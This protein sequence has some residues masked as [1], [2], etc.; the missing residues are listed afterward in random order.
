MRLERIRALAL[1]TVLLLSAASA[2]VWAQASPPDEEKLRSAAM[3]Y[4]DCVARLLQVSNVSG[5]EMQRI[6]ELLS[7]NATSLSGEDLEKYVDRLREAVAELRANVRGEALTP[8][9]VVVKKMS[10]KV[11]ERLNKTG[12]VGAAS[13][14][15][16]AKSLGELKQR[17]ERRRAEIETH[18]AI[19]LGQGLGE[20]A[21]K[22]VEK[23]IKERER[24]EVEG[25]E[26]AEEEVSRSE[27]VL[28]E[29]LGRLRA[30]NASES[31]INAVDEALQ[32]VSAARET[33]RAAKAVVANVTPIGIPANVSVSV[34]LDV[35]RAVL[36]NETIDELEAVAEVL[37]ELREFAVEN[38][39][40][41][42]AARL[43]SILSEA[44]ELS[45]NLSAA[46]AGEG[47]FFSLIGKA[48]AFVERVDEE[49]K[50]LGLKH[51]EL[52]GYLAEKALG[53][54]DDAAS[55][56]ARIDS[57]REAAMSYMHELMRG[58]RGP[59][60]STDSE[61]VTKFHVAL[62]LLNNAK[63]ELARSFPPLEKIQ[64]GLGK[65]ETEKRL[66]ELV[67]P[68][69]VA[70]LATWISYERAK[71]MVG[72]A[73]DLLEQA[74]LSLEEIEEKGGGGHRGP[75]HR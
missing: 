18:S 17:L 5:Q 14:V 22:T 4:Q 67:E 11:A 35:T 41:E 29:V 9:E 20:H 72:A 53:L 21:E 36:V 32:R 63:S 52:G 66:R 6:R 68:R 37:R 43:S 47:D 59:A 39:L 26:R 3:F 25:L 74:G 8:P 70:R 44:E 12:A 10:E 54:V 40:T 23:M 24:L 71:V 46:T 51:P 58:A 13:E 73:E 42:A 45:S 27:E 49:V 61:A 30:L 33:L 31:A 15:L 28:A 65:N 38:N 7:V 62:W 60:K 1:V 19:R 75:P 2:A 56:A 69:E 16:E 55:L 57:L 50:A 48:R 34:A 64:P